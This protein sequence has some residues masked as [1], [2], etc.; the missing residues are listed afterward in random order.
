M[1]LFAGARADERIDCDNAMAQ[2]D[3][4]ICAS[5][6]YDAADARLNQI[7]RKLIARLDASEAAQLKNA[8]RSWIGYRDSECRYT[9]RLN[10]GGSIY[11]T[12]WFGCLTQQ[13]E[14]R[15]KVL[16]AH[17]DCIN[18]SDDCTE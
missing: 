3:I 12:V 16:K 8:E 13:T 11:P 10:E 15:T 17:L 2:N 18:N 14:S 4:N 5:R 9:V 1:T 7:Y 6:A